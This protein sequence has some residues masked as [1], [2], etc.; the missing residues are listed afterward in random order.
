MAICRGT[1]YSTPVF[2]KSHS[3]LWTISSS[4]TLGVYER[5]ALPRRIFTGSRTS[6]AG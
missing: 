2:A 6:L 5:L 3:C 4:H 1:G